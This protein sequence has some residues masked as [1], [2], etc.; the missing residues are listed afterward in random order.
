MFR[1]PYAQMRIVASVAYDTDFIEWW[2][3]W[4]NDLEAKS[5]FLGYVRTGLVF[6]DQK[7]STPECEKSKKG[8]VNPERAVRRGR[9]KKI[10]LENYVVRL[11]ISS[12]SFSDIITAW[13]GL[14]KTFK[15]RVFISL[16]RHGRAVD[17]DPVLMLLPG[18]KMQ[19]NRQP[20]VIEPTIV[21][22]PV[23]S[24]DKSVDTLDQ[25]MEV[26]MSIWNAKKESTS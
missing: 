9:K 19:E 21:A 2:K 24:A 16:W 10:L 17:H 3:Q 4:N 20:V 6:R 7:L 18:G 12:N 13:N 22:T 1:A 5:H 23:R 15:S 14:P 26:I 8:A 25:D 11:H